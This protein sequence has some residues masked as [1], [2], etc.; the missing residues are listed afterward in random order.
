MDCANADKPERRTGLVA[1]E[2]GSYNIDIAAL[3]ETRF[4]NEDQLTC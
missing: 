2:L 3:R 1:R 4:V